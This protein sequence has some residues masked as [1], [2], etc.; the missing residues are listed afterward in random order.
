MSEEETTL[1]ILKE[2]AELGYQPRFIISS[3]KDRV[4]STLIDAIVEGT[5]GYQNKER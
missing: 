3:L 4:P 2:L 1:N 5:T